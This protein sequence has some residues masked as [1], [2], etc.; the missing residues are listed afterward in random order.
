M[1]VRSTPKSLTAPA[2]QTIDF[3]S[4]FVNSPAALQARHEE[5]MG[6]LLSR[7][8]QLQAKVSAQN[9]TPGAPSSVQTVFKT[10][11]LQSTANTQSDLHER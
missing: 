10:K 6:T 2:Q 7:L 1:S 8:D 3:R 9:D 5:T 4:D 11:P